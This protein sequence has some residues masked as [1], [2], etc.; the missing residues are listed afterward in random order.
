MSTVKDLTTW[1]VIAKAGIVLGWFALFFVA[2]R[3]LPAVQPVAPTGPGRLVRNVAFWGINAVLSPLTVLPATAWA[4]AHHPYTRPDWWSDWP[5]LALDILI[6]DFLIYWWH[7]ANHEW[8]WLWRFHG[9]HHLDQFL[10]STTAV[11]FHFGEMLLSAGARTIVVLLAA[12]PFSSIVVFEALLLCATIF[13]HSNLRLPPR[14]ERVLSWV[15]VTPGIHW[16]HHHAVRT[17]T[18]SNYG[19]LFSFWDWSFRT[20]SPT[21]RTPTMAIGVEGETDRT[22][23]VLLLRPFRGV[24]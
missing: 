18:D 12:F 13:H 8:P 1:L 23:P 20:R 14:M 2:E 5:G 10:D 16:V 6:L 24:S 21:R 17:D 19:T 9:V 15:I 11:R 3:L 4:A 22:L 7:R